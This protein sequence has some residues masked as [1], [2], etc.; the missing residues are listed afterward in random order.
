MK[1]H[2]R[3]TRRRKT[4]GGM[5]FSSKSSKIVPSA[6][7]TSAINSINNLKLPENLGQESSKYINLNLSNIILT[8]HFKLVI[9]QNCQQ[10]Q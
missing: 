6:T 8:V 5:F 9:T 7:V 3:K 4:R 2:R 10:I 1:T